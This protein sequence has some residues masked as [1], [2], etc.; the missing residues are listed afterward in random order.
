MIKC[1]PDH[2]LPLGSVRAA[3]VAA[4]FVSCGFPSLQGSETWDGELSFDIKETSLRTMNFKDTCTENAIKKHTW[5]IKGIDSTYHKL[6]LS[7][8][9]KIMLTMKSGS[10][11]SSYNVSFYKCVYW[12]LSFLFLTLLLVL[13]LS[14]LWTLTF[15][16]LLRLSVSRY[17]SCFF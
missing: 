11:F 12:N 1:G 16:H 6:I 9:Y 7:N 17:I 14:L 3:A 15:C 2:R 10:S 8:T 4:R 13:S 5:K